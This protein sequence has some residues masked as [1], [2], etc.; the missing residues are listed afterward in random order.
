M[1]GARVINHVYVVASERVIH[2]W[3]RGVDGDIVACT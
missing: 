2:G 3:R 1:T